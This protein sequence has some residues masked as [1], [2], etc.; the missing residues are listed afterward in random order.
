[1]ARI[2][3]RG[4]EQ[5]SN[6]VGIQPVEWD[7]TSPTPGTIQTGTVRSGTYAGEIPSLT[8]G[9][10]T[11]WQ[12]QFAAADSTGPYFI[13]F[14][15]LLHTSINV[16]SIIFQYGNN[17]GSSQPFN[18]MLTTTDKLRVTNNAGTQ[19]GSDSSALSKDTWYCI[20]AKYDT[21][22][23]ANHVIIE[24]RIDGSNFVSSNTVATVTNV[25]NC[26]FGGNLKGETATTC[27]FFFDDIAVNDSTGAHET[28]YSYAAGGNKVIPLRPNAAGDVNTFATQTGGT[29]GAANNF[30]R[31]NEVTPDNATSF[32]GST[33]LNQEDLFNVTDSGIGA[34]DTV[35]VVEVWGT[36]RNSTADSVEAIVL[37]LLKTSGGTKTTS[38]NIIP[39][40]TSWLTNKTSGSS[41]FPLTPIIVSYTDPDGSA[42]TQ[43]TLDSMQIGY[44]YT[45]D[46]TTTRRIDVTQI[47]A[48]VDYTP[49]SAGG[50]TTSVAMPLMGVG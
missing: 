1:M 12:L 4:F 50:A 46:G 6:T 19:I 40:T 27:D 34:S 25:N 14:Y 13:R 41:G 48:L 16:N 33:T 39:N 8:S 36:W 23:G 28:G 35:N 32:N 30:T 11:Y 42:W 44:K 9:F 43:T 10:G 18:I 45:I 15:Y 22:G 7:G 29:A 20:E 47:H 21:T 38:G 31:V 37:E 2:Y 26:A 24:A 5:N 17:A 3:T 49:V